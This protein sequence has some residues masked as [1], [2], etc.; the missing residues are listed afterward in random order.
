MEKKITKKEMY[1]RAIE[2]LSAHEDMVEFFSHE[3]ELLD[4]KANAKTNSKAAK[5]K[6]DKE[7]LVYN[8]LAE[9][10]EPIT[11]TDFMVKAGETLNALVEEGETLSV[12]RITAY[13]KKLVDSGRVEKT[14]VKK[15]SY[16][17]VIRND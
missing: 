12:Q 11:A 1:T 15:K 4:R 10:N 8:A 6:A 17:A 16:F 7:E 3:I 2:L 9:F 13:L 5:A 14:Q